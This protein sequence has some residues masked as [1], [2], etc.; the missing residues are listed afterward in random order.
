MYC[1]ICGDE[2][3]V[4]FAGGNRGMLCPSCLKDTPRK[5]GFDTFCRAYFKGD[6]DCP[7][8]IRHEFYDDYRASNYTLK[9]Y[10][11]K[12]TEAV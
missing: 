3:N 2:N 11:A 7:V 4:S 8:A 12:T 5:V 1:R 10:I 9:Q 6:E